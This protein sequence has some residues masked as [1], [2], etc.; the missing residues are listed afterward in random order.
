MDKRSTFDTP[1]QAETDSARSGQ[2][3]RHQVPEQL[4]IYQVFIRNYTQEGTFTAAISRLHEIA[5]LGCSWI[6]LTPIHP[7]GTVNRKGSA[8]SPYAIRDYRS[9]NP[10]LGSLDDFKQ[11]IAAVHSLGLKLMIDVVYNHTAPDSLLAQAHPEWYMHAPDGALSRKCDDWS[12]VADFDYNAT[13]SRPALWEELIDTL[14]YWRSLGVDGFRCD[15]ASLVPVDFWIQ[16]RA[17]VNRFN[18]AT[19]KEDRPTLWLAE[20]VHPSFVLQLRTLGYQ[21][22]SDPEIHEAFDLSY[23][24]DGFEIL[25]QVWAGQKNITAYLDHVKL[26]QALYPASAQ[27]I[28][29]LENHDQKRAAWRFKDSDML[30]A[31]T[32]FYQFLPGCTFVYMGQEWGISEYPS[33]FEKQPVPWE[34][35]NS[36]FNKFFTQCFSLTQQIK[37]HQA[38]FS[39]MA[40]ADGII[41]LTRRGEHAQWHALCNLSA[42]KGYITIP[43]TISGKNLFDNK[44]ITLCGKIVIPENCLLIEEALH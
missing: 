23:D 9:I 24:Y 28:R 12:D 42:R 5:E 17:R 21:A 14:E 26:Q 18:P 15:V 16:A 35:K 44:P 37:A 22:W 40:L 41:L 3:R 13:A 43:G 10:E 4:S 39:Y 2:A 20:T 34:T 30:K 33:L 29:F 7:I 32:L 1:E 25:E 31:W 11:F 36:E 27:K 6:Y 19:G 8:G 38:A